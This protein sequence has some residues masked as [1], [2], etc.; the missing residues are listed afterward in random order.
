MKST[1]PW[2]HFSGSKSPVHYW[3]LCMKY[4]KSVK[5]VKITKSE[6]FSMRNLLNKIRYNLQMHAQIYRLKPCTTLQEVIVLLNL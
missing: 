1:G 4:V 2:V 3:L 5:S 6:T